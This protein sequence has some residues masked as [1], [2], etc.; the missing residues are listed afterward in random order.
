MIPDGELWVKIGGDKG[1]GSFKMSFQ[2]CN[3]SNPNSVENTCVFAVCNA[4]DTPAN[5]H[6]ALER[7]RDQVSNLQTLQLRYCYEKTWHCDTISMLLP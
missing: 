1:G 6:V 7:Y 3:V 5:L 4:S 2:L